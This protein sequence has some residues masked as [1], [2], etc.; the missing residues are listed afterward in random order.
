M[1]FTEHLNADRR[2]VLL[3]LLAEQIGYKQ[4]SSNL[5]HALDRLGHVLSRDQVKAQLAWLA[6]QE[7]VAVDEPVPGVLVAT[8]TER[9][10]DV[11][12]GRAVVPGVA[13]PGA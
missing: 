10:H 4:N 5:T 3:R 13:R 8:L 1:N 7:L 11:A 12:R 2:L 6:E 9:G